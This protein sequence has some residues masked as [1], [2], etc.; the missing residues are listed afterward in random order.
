MRTGGDREGQKNRGHR[1]GE[2][3][4]ETEGN[5][6]KMKGR[7]QKTTCNGATAKSI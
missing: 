6:D 1:G 5:F 3:D 4:K 2:G 7:S